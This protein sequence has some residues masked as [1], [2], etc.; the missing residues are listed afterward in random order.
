MTLV[1]CIGGECNYNLCKS[2]RNGDFKKWKWFDFC[3]YWGISK[4]S[5]QET[6]S[7]PVYSGICGVKLKEKIVTGGHFVTYVSTSWN[8]DVARQFVGG[9]GMIIKVD[10]TYKDNWDVFCCDVSWISSFANECEILFARSM[11]HFMVSNKFR[12]EILNET[13]G[14][15]TVL[16]RK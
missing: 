3:L 4:L 6:G 16:L 1:I 12:L 15:Q 2:Q 9:D 14:V 8:E 10:R 7:F 11:K 13:S 5:E